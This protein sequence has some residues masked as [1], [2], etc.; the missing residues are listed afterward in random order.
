MT[1][2]LSDEVPSQLSKKK[3]KVLDEAHRLEIYRPTKKKKNT[4]RLM[5]KSNFGGPLTFI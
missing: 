3:K 1:S 4:E 2:K 5:D